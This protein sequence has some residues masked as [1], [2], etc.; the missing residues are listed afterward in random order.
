MSKSCPVGKE[1]DNFVDGIKNRN[2][3]LTFSDALIAYNIYNKNN[4]TEDNIPTVD[5]AFE[6]LNN[7]T[8]LEKDEEFVR[9]SVSSKVEK[10]SEQLLQ[11]SDIY[12]NFANEKQKVALEKIIDMTENHIDALNGPIVPKTISVSNFIGTSTFKGDPTEYAAFRIFGTFIHDLLED[13]Q[14][15]SLTRGNI[16]FR[17]IFTRDYFNE[18]LKTFKEKEPFEIQSLDDDKLFMMSEDLVSQINVLRNQGYLV[19]PEISVIGSDEN[20]TMI[21]G[22]IDMLLLDPQG[23]A[24]VYDFKTKKVQ[25]LL[26]EGEDWQVDNAAGALAWLALKNTVYS[27]KDQPEGAQTKFITGEFGSRSAYDTWAMQTNIYKNILEQIGL[28]VNGHTILS[29]L[30]ETDEDKNFLGSTIHEFELENY[31]LYADHDML[32]DAN[33]VSYIA[34]RQLDTRIDKIKALVDKHIPT[35]K[36]SKEIQ[37]KTTRLLNEVLQPSDEDYILMRENIKRLVDKELIDI[38]NKIKNAKTI[39]IK[40]L[41]IERRDSLMNY[42]TLLEKMS[43]EDFDKSI[44][45]A[46][47]LDYLNSELTFLNEKAEE[48]LEKFK[49]NEEAFN[50]NDLKRMDFI[51]KSSEGLSDVIKVMQRV[52]N[53]ARD[54]EE[55]DI[56]ETSPAVN[57]LGDL[58][59]YKENI[60][61]IKSQIY[62]RQAVAKILKAPGKK[63]FAR[64]NEQMT[65]I[66]TKEIEVL[67]REIEDLQSNK[68]L[69][70]LQTIKSKALRKISKSY[71]EKLSE[72][73]GEDSPKLALIEEKERMISVF[74]SL[75]AG[76]FDYTDSAVLAYL[77]NVTNPDSTF[78]IGSDRVL[79]YSSIISGSLTNNWVASVANKDLALSGATQFL[80]NAAAQAVRNA[81][82]NFASSNFDALREKL[83]RSGRSFEQINKAITERVAIK[84]RDPKTKELMER[85]VLAIV[86]P[87]TQEYKDTWNSYKA[88]L[89]EADFKI[90][91]LKSER[92]NIFLR[93]DAESKKRV[94][95]LT[96][97]IIDAQNDRASKIKAHNQWMIENSSLPYIDEFYTLQKELPVEIAEKLQD[98]YLELETYRFI[99]DKKTRT[100]DD[101]ALE[102]EDETTD[103]DFGRI[104][105]IEDDIKSLREEAKELDPKY[106]EYMSRLDEFYEYDVRYDYFQRQ[107][108]IALSKFQNNPEELQKWMDENEIT[109]AKKEWYE[110]LSALY[111][112]LAVYYGSDPV[113]KDMLDERN[114][115]LRKH[116]YVDGILRPQYMSDEDVQKYDEIEERI[117]EYKKSRKSKNLD[118]AGRDEVDAIFFKIQGLKQKDKNKYYVK[119]YDMRFEKLN[120]RLLL[121]REQDAL[122]ASLTAKGV[123]GEELENVKKLLTA[124]E[125]QFDKEE[126]EFKKWYNKNHKNKYKSITKGYGKSYADPKEFNYVTVPAEAVKEQY[127][128][129]VPHPKYT[130]RRM[131]QDA[132]YV[133]GIK[134]TDEQKE[135]LLSDNNT[136]T[137]L[138]SEGRLEFEKGVYNPNYLETPDGIPMPK[139]VIKV[140]DNVYAPKPGAGLQN[141][142]PR[143]MELYKDKDLFEFYAAITSMFFELQK[144]TDGKTLGY[145][146]PGSTSGF[147]QSLHSEGLSSA[148][149]KQKE[150]FVDKNIKAYGS[151]QDIN[152]NL[153]GDLKNSIRLRGNNQFDKLIQSDDAVSSVMQWVAEAHYNIAMQEAAPVVDAFVDELKSKAAELQE[154]VKR[155]DRGVVRD[156]DGSLIKYVD[157]EQRLSE[158]NSIIA[159]TEYERNKFV[160]GQYEDPSAASRAMTKRLNAFFTYTSFIRIGF[161]VTNQTKNLVAG[162]IQ[163]YI[164]A[165]DFQTGHYG[166]KDYHWANGKMWGFN[167]S[168]GRYLKDLGNISD[169][170]QET[171]TYRLFNPVQ[172]EFNKYLKDTS[173]KISRKALDKASSITELAFFLQDKGDTIIGMTVMWSVLN[174]YKYK[175]IEKF[176]DDGQPVYVKDK[177]GE[178][179]YI[180][181]HECYIKNPDTNELVIRDD[182]EY[183]VDDENMLRN[184]IYSEMRRAQGN[185]AKSDQVKAEASAL[186]KMVL[187]FRKYLIPMFM[188]RFGYMKTNWE[189]GEVAIGYWRAVGMAYRQFGG[190]Q[191]AKH[192]LVGGKTLNRFNANTMGKF[193]TAKVNHARRDLIAMGI[194]TALSMAALVYYKKRKEDDPDED[195]LTLTQ[196]YKN[197]LMDNMIRL[198]WQVKGETTSMFPAG[199]GQTEYIRNFTTGIPFV[200]E[201]TASQKLVT[202]AYSTVAVQLSNG[203]EEPDEDLDSQWYQQ[204]WKDAYYSRKS[205]SYEKGDSKLIKDFVDL[206]GIRN[207]RDLLNPENRL[208]F[209]QSKQ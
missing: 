199:E 97:E 144:Q 109:I 160:S 22:R 122:Y 135:E 32:L 147:I 61:N 23:N 51:Y 87:Y 124:Y 80:K 197:V 90:R 208:E 64:I 157:F 42:K 33:G 86:A 165:C 99:Q 79:P 184:I 52:I 107:K 118:D 133:D 119:E 53:E 121:V 156:I 189:A 101:E 10:Y 57:M 29:L 35:K 166:K 110:D 67:Q 69:T 164:A 59:L 191:V 41:S 73:L 196:K 195:E 190:L 81:Q 38:N 153:F 4:N 170:S 7:I 163:S 193:M 27:T 159:L 83:Y 200:R 140:D 120:N 36:Q 145:V 161:D 174:S 130:K 203:G 68:G 20:G 204:N 172:K 95:E 176:T 134:L 173:G 158:L 21:V 138:R 137:R 92:N 123:T 26:E 201:F 154:K 46:T 149:Q 128:E 63:V 6:I 94:E 30:Y 1:W 98:L 78:Y 72:K 45:T 16:S 60:S 14:R 192:L 31:Y 58:I 88:F 181:A 75:I 131:K 15:Q 96:N 141:I 179:V 104:G 180:S 77:D 136:M 188:N 116:K 168:V 24:K 103:F 76:T 56:T 185:Y 62:R 187:F 2:N 89:K 13:V 129:T 106:A 102:N 207:F 19:L 91:Q 202:H 5:E 40:K 167:G 114:K 85:E 8:A 178:D 111:E 183:T 39:A 47:A 169:I 3:D 108:S 112:E 152:E 50:N 182:V 37:V 198:I 146:V 71:S 115:I 162:S 139:N 205:G 54:N 175:Q 55:N 105:E 142:N 125:L 11:L 194:L 49:N 70:F 84:Y 177:N 34:K 66:V 65:E 93:R 150:I 171:M 28:D 127:T 117:D 148:I 82:N 143:Y 206:T 151:A 44:N 155:S 132:Y 186:G 17:K 43:N 100:Y 25:G 209:L 74:K 9:L 126:R 48:L 12:Q 18:R 113:Y